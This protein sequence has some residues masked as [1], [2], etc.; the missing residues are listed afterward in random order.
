[1]KIA[2]YTHSIAPSIDGVCRRFTGLLWEL[3]RQN[4]EVLL[5]TLEDEPEDIPPSTQCIT[6]PHT[7]FDF[8]PGKKVALST[9]TTT[10]RVYSGLKKFKPDIIHFTSDGISLLFVA[11]GLALGI[12]VVA[13]FHTDIQ[14]LLTSLKESKFYRNLCLLKEAVDSLVLDSCATTSKSFL[15]KLEKQ[16]VY[17]Q[18]IIPSAVDTTVFQPS[19][20]NEQLRQELLF[21]NKSGFLCVYV[22][23]ISA[24]KRL[25]VLIN[26]IKN[27]PDVYLAIV[28]GGPMADHYS[29]YHG[30]ENRI[31]CKPRFLTHEELA[32]VYASSDVHVSASEFET[33]GNTVLESLACGTPV[34]VARTQGFCDTV[35]HGVTGFLFTPQSSQDCESYIS[36]LQQDPVLTRKMG[37]AGSSAMA[38]RTIEKVCLYVCMFVYPFLQLFTFFILFI[39]CRWC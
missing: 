6:I 29:Q 18:F 8:Y 13:S 37:S 20:R 2:I 25:D 38:S 22:G 24:E 39:I 9:M 36:K 17:C 27:I 21:G 4:H 11:C 35:T 3:H 26:A 28:G 30:A 10:S 12:P 32:E 1:M 33:L 15:E 14:D 7:M 31:H 5:F 34:V 23:R 16:G 19:R